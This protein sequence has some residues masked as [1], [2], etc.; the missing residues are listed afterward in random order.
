MSL[1]ILYD[2]VVEEEESQ[3]FVSV[4]LTNTNL[5]GY[6][7]GM[8]SWNIYAN[9]IWAKKKR[10]YYYADEIVSGVIY[11]YDGS[12]LIDSISAKNIVINTKVNNLTI[13]Q[14]VT[15]R[16]NLNDGKQ[17]NGLIANDETK[18][19]IQIKSTEM[20]YFGDNKRTYLKD[21]ELIKEDSIIRPLKDVEI[22]NE[23]NIAYIYHGFNLKNNK[24]S[25]TGNQ[26]I[27]YIDDDYSEFKGD[28]VFEQ[29]PTY[30][31]NKSMD[32]QEE[33]LRR[34]LHFCMLITL[35]F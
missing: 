11:D 29:F 20:R 8:L 5:S 24:V 4:E 28:L 1:P 19:Q 22:D 9:K 13:K 34:N 12:V 15:A 14:G 16:L 35:V 7:K 17:E 27:L 18:K 32:E 3:E 2:V 30:N 31:L 10:Y 25:V 26:M 23:K 6:D 33:K 21:V